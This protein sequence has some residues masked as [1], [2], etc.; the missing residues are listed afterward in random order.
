MRNVILASMRTYARRYVAAFVAVLIATGF[1]VAINTLSAA[2]RQGAN[3]TV[4]RQYRGADV[5]ATA[6]E[7]VRPYASLRQKAIADPGVTASAV[8]WRG[9]I[10]ATLPDGPRTV[11]IGSVATD[12]ALRW[13]DVSAGRLPTARGEV[14]VSASQAD[15]RHIRTGDEVTLHAGGRDLALTVTGIV[16]DQDGPLRSVLYVPERTFT[17]LG[18][19]AEPVDEIFAVTGDPGA[20]ASRLDH[21]AAGVQVMTADTYERDLRLQAT[22]GID[23]FQKLIL[24]FAAISLFVG[25]LV[26]A[27]TFTILLAQ[28]ARDLALLRCVGAVRG[29]IARSVVAEGLVVGAAGAAAGVALGYVIALA[30]GAAIGHWS[31]STPMGTPT[32][33]PGGV[34]LPVLLG[35]G[36]T[37]AAS[38]FPA[39]RAGSRSPLAALQPQESVQVRTKAG[40]LRIVSAAGLISVGACG[41]LVGLQG[42]IVAGLLGGMLSF[43]GV[44]LLAPVLVPAVIRTARP[45]AHLGGAPGRLAHANS[46]RNPRR[47]AA[48]STALLI[49]VTLITSV[50]VGSASIS[51]KVNTSLDRNLPVD[52]L[53]SADKGALPDG[54]SKRLAAV[55]GVTRAVAVPGTTARLGDQQVTVLGV[56]GAARATVRGNPLRGLGDS[57]IV[58]PDTSGDIESGSRVTLD[59]GGQSRELTVRHVSG[60][61]DDPI[62]SRSLLDRLGASTTTRATWVR[63]TDGADAG[64]VTADVHAITRTADLTIAG[65]LPERADILKILA[66]VLAI[67]V[68]FLGIAVLIALIGV[69]NTLS[70]SVLERVREN[71]LLR[72]MGLER[73]GLRAMLAI[74][75][76]LMAGV[77]AVLGI[78]L[79][80]LYAWFGVKTVT[81]GLFTTAPSLT[82][83]WAQIAVI[84]A[85]AAAAGLVA[86]VLPARQAARIA[87]AAGLVAD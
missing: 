85:V 43:V 69:G 28:R 13:Q 64:D 16:D 6:T 60:L 34:L 18:D 32:L 82:V 47:T 58:L 61:G 29:Q 41:L 46:M 17:V 36:V 77:S 54:I 14:A 12:R 21:A 73:S 72:A 59:V 76:L 56:D 3:D 52:L 33:T 78:A 71:S 22:K 24:V 10:D 8:N 19:V 23:I 87:P 68:G 4:G 20:V 48:T 44:L 81:D 86:C 74:E 7:G 35:M 51:H 80:T 27:N 79:G 1:I 67:T 26:I 83:P 11:S 37:V 63:A 25:A 5:A 84:F 9:W 15:R 50:V 42:T 2:A 62:V 30:G 45:L 49:G 57:E 75:A 66:I 40:A 65:G 39:R 53:V 70:L 31:P 38:W 55:D